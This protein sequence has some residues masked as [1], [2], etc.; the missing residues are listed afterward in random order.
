VSPRKALA[1]ARSKSTLATTGTRNAVRICA[2]VV[3]RETLAAT[4]TAAEIWRDR[5][6]NTI[7]DRG[8]S[9]LVVVSLFIDDRHISHAVYKAGT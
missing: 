2:L 4:S 3:S 1:S 6:P 5:R 9:R 7:E 8:Y